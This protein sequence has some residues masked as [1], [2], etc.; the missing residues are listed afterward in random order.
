MLYKKSSYVEEQII[1]ILTL[2][3]RPK[4]LDS[5]SFYYFQVACATSI[6]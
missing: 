1:C 3:A 2:L 5:T 4:P 6:L